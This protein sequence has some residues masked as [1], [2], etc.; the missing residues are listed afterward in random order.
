M[1]LLRDETFQGYIVVVLLAIA[2]VAL[3]VLVLWPEVP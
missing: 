3:P 1:K 2:A